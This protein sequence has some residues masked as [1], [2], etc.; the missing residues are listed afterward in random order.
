MTAREMH[1]EI[2]QSLQKVA[3]NAT[4][5]F[6]SEEIDWVLNKVQERFI[7][8]CLRPVQFNGNNNGQYRFADQLRTDAI[9]SLIVS[10]KT[11]NAYKDSEKRVKVYLPWNYM[12]MLADQSNMLNLCGGPRVETTETVTIRTLSLSKTTSTSVPYYASDNSITVN[13]TVL[14]I[15]GSL[16]TFN[17]YTGYQKKEDV[18]FL[19]NWILHQLQKNGVEVYWEKFGDLYYQ[20]K[21]IFKGTP[22]LELKWD[23]TVVTSFTDIPVNFITQNA[24]L[25]VTNTADNRITSSYD[26]YTLLNTPFAVTTIKSPISE[27]SGNLLYVYQD[28]NTTVKSVTISYVRIPQS[29]SLSLGTNCELAEQF[30]QVICDLTVEY[31]KGTQENGPGTTIKKQDINTRVIL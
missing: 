5:K 12:Y 25:A 4:R 16:G 28:N 14:N 27:L 19:K 6:L 24:A 7:Q 30:H 29:I 20:D 22:T 21:F 8:D 17:S 10:G 11:I 18:Y 15:P 3:A 2:N 31:I 1:I 26:V 13:S 9:R 23:N